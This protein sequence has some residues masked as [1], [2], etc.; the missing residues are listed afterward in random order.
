VTTDHDGAVAALRQY[1]DSAGTG[2][3]ETLTKL[4]TAARPAL[5]TH[6]VAKLWRLE[7]P[8]REPLKLRS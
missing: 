4:L 2:D 1:L 6:E 7:E 5:A 8:E 3:I